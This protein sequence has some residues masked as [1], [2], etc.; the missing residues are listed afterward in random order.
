MTAERF[1]GLLIKKTRLLRA[2]PLFISNIT[3]VYFVVRSFV[4][5]K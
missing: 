3:P 4:M 2:G 5:I 1:E